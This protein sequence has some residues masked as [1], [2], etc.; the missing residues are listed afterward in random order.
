MWIFPPLTWRTTE[1]VSAWKIHKV[2]WKDIQRVPVVKKYPSD[3]LMSIV[4]W[5]ERFTCSGKFPSFL[6]PEFWDKFRVWFC[7][8][9]SERFF[10]SL[11]RMTHVDNTT[12]LSSSK[13]HRGKQGSARVLVH[14]LQIVDIQWI[15]P[16]FSP[17]FR[18]LHLHAPDVHHFFM[19]H[20]SLR[21]KPINIGMHFL[22]THVFCISS[23]YN[24]I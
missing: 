3:V 5:L 17:N 19:N 1:D 21:S 16:W 13:F 7:M 8:E 14:F 6:N 23:L 11:E 15:L 9:I 22:R 10:Y 24:R 4:W 18:F 20:T 12:C 2:S